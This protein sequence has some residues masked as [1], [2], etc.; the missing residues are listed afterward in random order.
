MSVFVNFPPMERDEDEGVRKFE[1]KL[2]AYKIES[3]N[4]LTF[5]SVIQLKGMLIIRKI[6]NYR[7]ASVLW[8]K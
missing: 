2:H 5:L 8:K 3:G 4:K 7:S 1:V 6:R